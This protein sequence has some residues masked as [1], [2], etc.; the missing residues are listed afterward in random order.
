MRPYPPSDEPM[1]WLQWV[2]V[3]LGI[4]LAAIF[5][6]LRT[7]GTASSSPPGRWG[8]VRLLTALVAVGCRTNGSGGP[9]ER[10][11]WPGWTASSSTGSPTWVRPRDH[12]SQPCTL[13]TCRRTPRPQVQ[14][15]SAARRHRAN[16]ARAQARQ[17]GATLRQRNATRATPRAATAAPPAA[18]ARRRSARHVALLVGSARC[19][20]SRAPPR[21][22]RACGWEA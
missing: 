1:N 6:A 16:R 9:T 7:S 20:R 14:L 3:V 4:L 10:W 15:R 8:V 17:F 12:G 22:N 5:V 11:S 13:A 19:S 2:F 18:V 21:A